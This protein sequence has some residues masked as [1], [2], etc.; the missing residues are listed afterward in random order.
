MSLYTLFRINLY[1]KAG[2]TVTYVAT[3]SITGV[4]TLSQVFPT[5]PL[6]QPE[7]THKAFETL[8]KVCVR[9]AV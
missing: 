3:V 8:K 6:S 9:K 7:G 5:H 2:N 4:Q 1:P